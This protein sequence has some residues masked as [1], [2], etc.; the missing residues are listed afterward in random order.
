[1]YTNIGFKVGHKG[2]AGNYIH[3]T[4]ATVMTN[5]ERPNCRGYPKGILPTWPNK[6]GLANF[7]C[8]GF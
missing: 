3:I 6:Y 8:P 4:S 1:M 5:S 2:N 7:D